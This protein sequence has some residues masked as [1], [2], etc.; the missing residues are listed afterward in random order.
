MA[1]DFPSPTPTTGGEDPSYVDKGGKECKDENYF[2]SVCETGFVDP[3]LRHT[4]VEAS[5]TLHDCQVCVTA[6]EV[7]EAIDKLNELLEDLGKVMDSDYEMHGGGN[8]SHGGSSEY[9][10]YSEWSETDANSD[11]SSTGST[12]T[13]NSSGKCS[14]SGG[15]S[16]RASSGGGSCSVRLSRKNHDETEFSPLPGTEV[17]E[18]T[19]PDNNVVIE[20]ELNT[21]VTAG[22]QFK[23]EYRNNESVD[24]EVIGAESYWNLSINSSGLGLFSGTIIGDNVNLKTALQQLETGVASV[25]APMM[26]LNMGID[27]FKM[28]RL[29]EDLTGEKLIN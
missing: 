28:A 7:R 23:L 13:C 17:T 29:L 12:V 19:D 4:I 16:V 15:L 3:V 9:E 10:E 1:D 20:F 11:Y 21:N 18:S 14:M 5:A 25:M 8:E 6:A 2:I 22:D 27:I 26:P 24:H